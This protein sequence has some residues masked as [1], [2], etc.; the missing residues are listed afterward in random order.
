MDS[1]EVEVARMK[2]AVRKEVVAQLREALLAVLDGAE[3]GKRK[4]KGKRKASSGPVTSWVADDKA[5][6][7]PNFVIKATGLK[8]KQ[9]VVNKYGPNAKFTDGKPLPP[10]LKGKSDK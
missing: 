10:E 7:V 2:A 1:V 4:R 5:K 8:T 6:R 9:A 3:P